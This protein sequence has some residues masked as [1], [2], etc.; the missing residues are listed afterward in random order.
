MKLSPRKPFRILQ[1]T[2]LLGSIFLPG[3]LAADPAPEYRSALFA[4]G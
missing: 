2:C 1:L 3:I 4:A